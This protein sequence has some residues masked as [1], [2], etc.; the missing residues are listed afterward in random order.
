MSDSEEEG[1]GTPASGTHSKSWHGNQLSPSSLL[2]CQPHAFV[3]SSLE[4]K[5]SRLWSVSFL[6]FFEPCQQALLGQRAGHAELE[7]VQIPELKHPGAPRPIGRFIKK[8]RT[9]RFDPFRRSIHRGRIR[10][11]DL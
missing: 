9:G 4:S 10:N 2:R 3:G 8:R 5:E 7:S 6:S 11:V 1:R